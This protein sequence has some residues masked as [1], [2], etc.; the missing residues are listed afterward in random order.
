MLTLKIA[1]EIIHT[2]LEEAERRRLKPLAIVVLDGRGSIKASASQDGTSLLREKVAHG[3]AFG[4]LGLG[5]GSRA[6]FNRAQ[7]Q[8]YFV[9]AVNAIAGGSLVPVPGGVLVKSDGGETLGAVGISGDTSD[10]DEACAVT[11]IKAVSLQPDAG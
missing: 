8:P 5:L 2:A 1:Q 4:A 3:K 11:A 6:I 9:S 10:N 7:E